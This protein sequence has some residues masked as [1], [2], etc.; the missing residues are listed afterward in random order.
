MLSS[1]KNRQADTRLHECIDELH[2]CDAA[3][4]YV[5]QFHLE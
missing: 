4:L 3:Y 2:A 1:V 5:S